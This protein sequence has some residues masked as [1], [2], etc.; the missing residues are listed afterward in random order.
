MKNRSI[1]HI[2]LGLWM[3][4]LSSL[5][6]SCGI[7]MDFDEAT[8]LPYDM[9]L[10]RDTAYVF[11]GGAFV[12]NPLF[13]PDSVD[14]K[15]VF[16]LSD[17]DSIAILRNDSVVAVGVGE[18]RI[19]AISVLGDKK[20]YC[21]VFVMEPWTV[22]PYDYSDDMI[23]Y[24]TATIDGQPFDPETQLIGAFSGPEFRGIGQLVEWEGRKF[25]QFRIYGH[26]EWSDDEPTMPELIRF[27]YYD[28]DSLRVDYLPQTLFFD[29]ETHGSPSEPLQLTP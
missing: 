5:T 11:P 12:L 3:T 15:E 29:G 25:L 17:A 9:K 26:Y 22:N 28:I 7:E 6:M 23:V 4:V 16:F 20:A 10:N 8:L 18:T 13:I 24:A 27:A 14:N 21:N 2:A 1:R 19:T